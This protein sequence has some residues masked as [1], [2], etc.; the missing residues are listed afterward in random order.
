MEMSKVD[1]LKKVSVFSN[2]ISMF[3][4]FLLGLF[5]IGIQPVFSYSALAGITFTDVSESAG[6][7]QISPTWGVSWGDVNAD[8]WEDVYLS[9]HQYSKLIEVHTPPALFLNKG[10][11]VFKGIVGSYPPYEWASSSFGFSVI[12]P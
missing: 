6:I 8:G 4:Y 2:L 9:N 12:S 10:S 3:I 1:C 11:Y 7:I 5:L